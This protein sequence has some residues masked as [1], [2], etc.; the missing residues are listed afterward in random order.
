MD[1]NQLCF[2]GQAAANS[3][4]DMTALV[5]RD[6]KSE[7]DALVPLI[8]TKEEKLESARGNKAADLRKSIDVL[9]AKESV[10]IAQRGALVQALAPAPAQGENTPL[11]FYVSVLP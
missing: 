3:R 11:A 6:L 8:A 4:A 9:N 10:L 5:L 1:K 2:S 7:I